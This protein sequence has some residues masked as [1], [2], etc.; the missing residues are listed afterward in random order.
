MPTAGIESF[1]DRFLWD[2]RKPIISIQIGKWM[3]FVQKNSGVGRFNLQ[4]LQLTTLG[5]LS[6]KLNTKQE[7]E[8]AV[9][10]ISKCYSEL[11][12]RTQLIAS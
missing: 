6:S 4:R 12:T 8:T 7:V 10:I 2:Y 3:F 11:L 9:E 1:Q 5:T